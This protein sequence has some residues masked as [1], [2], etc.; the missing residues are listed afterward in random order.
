MRWCSAPPSR[1]V[2][3]NGAEA[4]ARLVEA[5]NL[6]PNDA[7]IRGALARLL[8]EDGQKLRALDEF[9]R[10]HAADPGHHDTAFGLA[11]VLIDLGR[12]TEARSLLDALA[13]Q[14]PDDPRV[15]KLLAAARQE[16]GDDAAALRALQAAARGAPEE[17]RTQAE[18][19]AALAREGQFGEAAAALEVAARAHP[20]DALAQ[21][22]LGTALAKAG[23]HPEAE[24]ALRAAVRL[25]PNDPRG[26]ENLGVLQE[27][28]G[29]V[30]GAIEAYE[31]MLKN[32]NNADPGGKVRQ[33]IE[34]LRALSRAP[35]PPSGR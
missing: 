30:D 11:A 27:E 5:A 12:A 19:G 21:L 1:V 24:A 6:M 32:V 14:R 25:A 26:W 34:A 31:S 4:I 10:A 22:R 13:L 33:R 29:D 18:L 3:A 2:R 35:G 17:V 15:Q 20:E 8:Y 23:K 7:G 16:S 28:R 9:R